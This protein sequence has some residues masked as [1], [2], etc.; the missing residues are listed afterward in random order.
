MVST[1]RVLHETEQAMLKAHSA[2][3]CPLF[4]DACKLARCQLW[5]TYETKRGEWWGHCGIDAFA[6]APESDKFP[7]G[8]QPAKLMLLPV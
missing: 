2:K 8:K 7:K 6:S 4:K 1:K 5:H 3:F